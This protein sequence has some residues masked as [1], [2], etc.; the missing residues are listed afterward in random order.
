MKDTLAKKK[1]STNAT[2]V[3]KLFMSFTELKKHISRTEM[4]TLKLLWYILIDQILKIA[5][6]LNSNTILK[7]WA[8]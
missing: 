4:S 2:S 5:Q 6:I 1:C 3:L 8:T 7:N